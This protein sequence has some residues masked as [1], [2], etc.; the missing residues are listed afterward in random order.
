MH[1]RYTALLAMYRL[2][3][4]KM[5]VCVSEEKGEY[6]EDGRGMCTVSVRI[7]F[8]WSVSDETARLLI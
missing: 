1:P 7:H 5:C 2:G 4:R 3:N 6:L 8:K